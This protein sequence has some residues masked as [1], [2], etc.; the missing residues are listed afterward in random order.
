MNRT[1]LPLLATAALLALDGIGQQT[2]ATATIQL[3]TELEL[4]SVLHIDIDLDGRGDLALGCHDATQ[5]RRELRVHRRGTGEV[6]FTGQPSLPPLPLDP[7]VIA[8]TFADLRPTPG[9]E[10]VLLTAERA[11][12]VERGEDGAPTYTA[13]GEL[14]LVWPA[15]A[16][17]RVMPLPDAC[18]DGDG[19]GRDDLLLPEPDGV[20][21][22]QPHAPSTRHRL[23]LPAWRSPLTGKGNGAADLQGNRLDLQLQLGDDDDEDGEAA[24][25][26]S[27]RGPLARVRQRA[28]Q[29]QALDLDGDG[30][31][32]LVAVRNDRLF[33]GDPRGAALVVAR[34]LPL[35]GDR[36]SLFDPDF[37]VQLV[38]VDGDRR[39][40]LLLTSSARRNDE[41]EVRIDLY[42]TRVDGSWADKPDS[43]LRMQ[44]LTMAPQLVDADGDGKLDVVAVTVR[45]DALRTLTAAGP[46]AIEAQLNIFRGTGERFAVPALLN[47]A[48]QLPPRDDRRRPFLHVVAGRDGAA[49]HVLLQQ[50]GALL[51]RPLQRNGERLLL[52][53]PDRRVPVPEQ[54]RLDMVGT[55]EVTVR[56]KRELLHVRL[57]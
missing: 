4:T 24:A 55:D 10:L 2:A 50:D 5:R 13:I 54:A 28:P 17:E 29:F 36:L 53:D 47:T 51:R 39:L 9:R 35:P 11:V 3:P 38:D 46:V 16:R 45:T 44:S 8:F 27:Q 49:G 31:R 42:R 12:L 22:L 25:G 6:A 57:P 1:P 41:V 33:V 26:R 19:D 23:S 20:L 14:S 48:L 40:D 30:R 21:W 32:E 56:S 15:A 7:D 34:T 52:A 18:I 37:D 43:R